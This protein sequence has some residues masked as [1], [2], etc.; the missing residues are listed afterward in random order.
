MIKNIIF[1]FGLVLVDWNPVDG[2][3]EMGFSDSQIEVFKKT[4]YSGRWEEYDGRLCTYEQ[5]IAEFNELVPGYEKEVLVLWDNIAMMT[6]QKPYAAEWISDLKSR[7]CSVY[8]LSNFGNIAWERCKPKYDFVD[9]LD[10]YVISSYEQCMKPDVR[11]YKILLDRYNL[12]AEE[13]LFVDD[14]LNNIEAAKRLGMHGVVFEN[15]EQ[16]KDV[17]KQYQKES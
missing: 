10:G 11:L 2:M 6:G 5:V 14:R 8:G 4:I 9:M 1:D 15:Y 12:K 7:G 17:V 3:R 13:S 16:A